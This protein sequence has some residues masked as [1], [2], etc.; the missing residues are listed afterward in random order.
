MTGL[1]TT[2]IDIKI[3]FL[4]LGLIMA[5]IFYIIFIIILSSENGSLRNFR[6]LIYLVI[7]FGLL[8]TCWPSY[9]GRSQI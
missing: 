1:D 6:R 8:N 2:L 4:S 7:F 3:A 9:S 5:I